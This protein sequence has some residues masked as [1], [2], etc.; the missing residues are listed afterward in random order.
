VLAR[1]RQ[2]QGRIRLARAS[3]AYPLANI[4]VASWHATYRDLIAPHNLARIEFKRT[5]ARFRRHFWQDDDSLMHVLELKSGIV[6]YAC[7]GSTRDLGMRGEVYELYLDPNL[8]RRGHGRR[9]LSTALWALAGRGQSPAL[10]WVLSENHG[11]RRF[12][13]MMGGREIAEADA[14]FGDQT[15]AKTAYAWLDYLPWPE[16]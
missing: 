8:Q 6:G 7:S 13:E 15:L 11:A 10:V 12:Y 3:D 1:P 2:Q 4:H 14:R 5:L 9:L 16:D